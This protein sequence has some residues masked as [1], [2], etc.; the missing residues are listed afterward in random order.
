MK[1]HFFA[2][3]KPVVFLFFSNTILLPC[4]AQV[5]QKVK[6]IRFAN[7]YPF[8]FTVSN[9]KLFFIATDNTNTGVFVTDGTD[10]GT[11]KLTP[12]TGFSSIS[13]IINYNNKIYFAYNNGNNDYELWVSDGTVAGTSVFKDIN[14]GTT[15]SFPKNLTVANNKLFFIT[16]IDQ[17]LYVCDG[18][19]AGT[20]IIK[21]NGAIIFNGLAQFAILNNDIYFTSDNGTGSGYGMWKSDGTLAGTVL[22]MPN[23]VSTIPGDYAVLNNTLFFSADDGVHG[24]ELWTTN[25]TAGSTS[26]VTNLRADGG[27]VFA[28]G[29][30]YNMINFKNKIYFTASDDVHGAELFSSDG[31]VAGTQIVK[32]ILPGTQGSLPLKSVIYNGNLYFS[33]SNGAAT[34]GLWKS[35]GTPAGT[36][37]V[38]Q[39]GGNEPFLNDAKFAPTFNGLLYFV[40]NDNQFYPLWQTDGTSAGTKI[41]VFQNT[42]APAFSNSSDFKFTIFNNELYF[43]GQCGTISLSFQPCKLTNGTLPLTWLGVQAQWIS[44]SEAKVSW[45]VAEQKNV[46]DYTVQYSGDGNN[47]LNVCSIISS[48]I[49]SYNCTTPAY[50]N[51]NNYYRV[52][53][54]DIDGKTTYS[55]I[56]SLQTSTRSSLSVYPNP[57]KDKLYMQGIDNFSRVTIS[58]VNGKIISKTLFNSGSHFL[59]VSRLSIGVYFIKV[60]SPDK[61]QT[62]KFNKE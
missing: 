59:D 31:T 11:I 51:T 23:I 8:D 5:I 33:C 9:N 47:F 18:T 19:P 38:K 55:K 36:M 61:T 27:G 13:D 46:K 44:G 17:K 49:T 34:A 3:L 37:L 16:D 39:G 12:S 15:G 57:T 53:Q 10:V 52:M 28:S 14:P 48:E 54:T 62:V 30:P 26:L 22:I 20:T 24:T 1:T 42:T 56:V 58:D 50:K 41:A 7:S 45:Q 25:G 29:A 43:S 35:D 2:N 21:N 32:D 60:A 4:T 40:P 6:D